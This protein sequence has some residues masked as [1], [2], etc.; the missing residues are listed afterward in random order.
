MGFSTGAGCILG[1]QQVLTVLHQAS[2]GVCGGLQGL[3][4]HQWVQV[5]VCA[6]IMGFSWAGVLIEHLGSSRV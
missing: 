5:A 1:Q 2:A 4:L 6:R 3:Q